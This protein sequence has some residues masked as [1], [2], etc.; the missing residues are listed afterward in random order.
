M[1]PGLVLG[2]PEAPC[3]LKEQDTRT[4]RVEQSS[5]S[6]VSS[7]EI[8]AWTS[9]DHKI[10]WTVFFNVIGS[11]VLDTADVF[12]FRMTKS[13]DSRRVLVCFRSAEFTDSQTEIFQSDH[14][15]TDAVE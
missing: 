13:C 3:E 12:D 10:E 15:R 11:Q 6:R 14:A 2:Y 4:F 9:A 8:I 7:G 1:L 5:S